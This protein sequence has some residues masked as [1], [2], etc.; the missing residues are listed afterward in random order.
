MHPAIYIDARREASS[1]VA[2]SAVS[3]YLAP[4]RYVVVRLQQQGGQSMQQ[5]QSVRFVGCQ[6]AEAL[7]TGP[8][9]AEAANA[10]ITRLTAVPAAS[11]H[12][13]QVIICCALC[14]RKCVKVTLDQTNVC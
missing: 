7:P 9:F 13:V 1:R 4:A 8:A 11:A 2:A 5:L 10:A 6:S 12:M 3:A 14:V